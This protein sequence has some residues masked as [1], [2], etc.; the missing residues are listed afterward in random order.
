MSARVMTIGSMGQWRSRSVIALAASAVYLYGFPSANIPYIALV[1]FHLVTGIFLTILLLPFLV[2]LLRTSTPGAG[3]GW[4]LLAV[5]G[6][7]GVTLIFTGTPLGMK[8]LLYSHI[9]ACLLGVTLLAA[10]WLGSREWLGM[11]GAEIA[12]RSV[13]LVAVVAGISAGTWWYRTY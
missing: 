7:T 10:S 12:L 2:K 8:W 9:L 3:V 6:V 1:L 11:G 13:A 4:L 5:G